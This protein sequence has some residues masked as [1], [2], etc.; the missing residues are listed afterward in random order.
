MNPQN[1]EDELFLFQ[2][3]FAQLLNP[4]HPLVLL[5]NEID[6]QAFDERMGQYY[7]EDNGAVAKPTRLMVGIHY[8]KYVFNESDESVVAKWIENPYWQ[9]FC[10]F[11]HMQHEAPLH[12]S[13]LSRW[14][15]RIGGD[16]DSD[17]GDL[18]LLLEETISLALKLGF[19]SKTDLAK[20]NIDTTV[21]EKN[22]TYPTDSKLLWHAIQLLNKAAKE[23]GVTVRQSYRRVGKKAHVQASRYAHAR[24]FKRM[25]R[26][27]KTLRTYVGR[28]IRDIRRKVENEDERL[29]TLLDRCERLR[30]QKKKDSKKIY[31][32]VEPDVQCISKGKA[33]KRYE[34]GQKISLATTNDKNWF[35][36]CLLCKNNPYDGH[37]L[38][39]TLMHVESMTGVSL[40][41]VYVDK[42]YRGH[43]YK[44]QAEIHIAGSKSK[45]R[46]ARQRKRLKRRN[47]IEPKIGHLKFENRM[48]RCYL[49]G[50]AGDAANALL[51][52]AASNIQK[53][54]A[55]L[56]YGNG[57]KQAFA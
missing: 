9:Y 49:K 26:S 36:G 21:Q 5:A 10:G 22:I 48:N 19:V 46:T 37:T 35:A 8:L 43:G 39:D 25:R 52:A 53:I 38:E 55:S 50:L 15:K 33:H 12:P 27:L 20:L 13:T 7:C 45:S 4:N 2:S 14:R 18:K 56:S 1:A 29:E 57:K 23:R 42:G 31:S 17:G 6:W 54:L 11:T 30:D 44:G 47:A 28:L 40:K 32:L 24:H 16:D 41:E 3:H 34:F 51:A